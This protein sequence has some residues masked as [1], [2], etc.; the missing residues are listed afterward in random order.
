MIVVDREIGG[1]VFGS[2]GDF[3]QCSAPSGLRAMQPCSLQLSELL[4]YQAQLIGGEFGKLGDDFLR[5]HAAKMQLF[6]GL[7]KLIMPTCANLTLPAAARCG[8][9]REMPPVPGPGRS[10]DWH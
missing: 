4:P 1:Q 3:Q 7:V 9:T 8:G 2:T 6:G 5:A 10:Q